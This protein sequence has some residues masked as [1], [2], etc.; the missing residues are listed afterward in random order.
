MTKKVVLF[1]LAPFIIAA[2]TGCSAA[3]AKVEQ[4]VSPAP[5][6]IDVAPATTA[7]QPQNP[8]ATTAAPATSSGILTVAELNKNSATLIGKDVI[9]EG[10]IVQECG[11]GCWFNLQ[12]STGIVYVDLAPNNMVIP[13]KVGSKAKVYGKVDKKSG[14]TYVIGSKVEF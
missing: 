13:Q 11:S 10:K 5:I 4:P 7:A 2:I 9:M 3:R 8:A 6:N 14:V 1:A 12:D